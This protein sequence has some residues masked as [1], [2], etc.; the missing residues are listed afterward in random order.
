[1]ETWG[2]VQLSRSPCSF[3][4]PSAGAPRPSSMALPAMPVAGCGTGQL[5]RSKTRDSQA[6]SSL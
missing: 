6:Q 5:S 4:S 3:A 2:S 1:M